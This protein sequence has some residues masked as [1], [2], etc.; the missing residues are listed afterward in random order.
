M[1]AIPAS[2]L[3]VAVNLA[4]WAPK[5]EAAE[6]MQ[7]HPDRLTANC[8]AFYA[9]RGQ[10]VMAALP[11]GQT[12]WFIRRDLDPRLA[13]DGQ[14][15]TA[16]EA[17]GR[18][19]KEQRGRLLAQFACVQAF[20]RVLNG[21][22]PIGPAT[23]QLIQWLRE[24]YP[25]QKI[26]RSSLYRWERRVSERGIAGLMEKRGGH[27]SPEACDEAWKAFADFFLHQN[28]PTIRHCW[29]LVTDLAHLN[30]WR[31]LADAPTQERVDQ[32]ISPEKQAFYR[33]PELY[34][35]RF[36]PFIPQDEESWGANERW[37]SDHKQL[38]LWCRWRNTIVRPW[39][40]TWQDWRTRR[41]V[42]WVLSDCPNSDT[43]L[44]SL[45]NA[46]RDPSNFGGPKEVLTDNGRDY[47]CYS[48]WGS[49]KKERRSTISPRLDEQQARGMF[50]LMGFDGH[51]ARPENPNGKAR[52]ER[53]FGIFTPFARGYDSFCGIDSKS[54]PPQ[55]P[56]ILENPARIPHFQ[57]VT[58]DIGPYIEDFNNNADHAMD[59]LSENGVKLSP[60][61]AFAR[62]TTTR[63]PM[64]DPAALDL[65]LQHWCK[66]T[67]VGRNG[68]AVTIAGELKHFGHTCEALRPFKAL[69][70][71][72]RP[73]VHV[74]YDPEHLETVR[75]YDSKF[76]FIT[77]A[78]MN[79]VGG[80]VK[81]MTRADVT[82]THRQLA[83][84][85]KSL[86]HQA[87]YSLTSILTPEEQ[88]AQTTARRQRAERQAAQAAAQPM[89][90][91]PRQ[92][93]LDGESKHVQRQELKI[94]VGAESLS[95]PQRRIDINRLVLER[96][97]NA[98]PPA[99]QRPRRDL[100]MELDAGRLQ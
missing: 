100:L 8:R 45:G 21:R 3:P 43:I 57:T 99:T 59:D 47:A 78:A 53:R 19:G 36:A 26:T 69:H 4:E 84:Y 80:I 14:G 10:A 62:W 88:L 65:L 6:K 82:E 87:E 42:G 97:R 24:Q 30:G 68:I 91:A 51:F 81:G 89:N 25:D 67:T 72:N 1:S 13:T 73:T 52:Q 22:C 85:R 54:K 31:W 28:Q 86:K 23:G 44:A 61:G 60:N 90:I 38:D 7:V 64:A 11:G 58:S 39:I 33:D 35:K 94:A 77:V 79:R 75:V 92:T 49:T 95:E 27:R 93:P 18:C 5:Q 34:R 32:K 9:P 74:S 29:R 2:N 17:L 70:K 71:K 96:A 55:L 76:R 48:F 63:R 50:N 56:E 20:R 66:P 98:A 37:V 40:T 16:M 46:L 15:E 12:Q 83:A 41:I